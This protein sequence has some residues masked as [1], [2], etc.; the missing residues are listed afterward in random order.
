MAGQV[1][2]RHFNTCKNTLEKKEKANIS[3]QRAAAQKKSSHTTFIGQGAV[4]LNVGNVLVTT[5]DKVL[6]T[7]DYLIR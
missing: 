7:Q 1:L 4:I 6:N 3:L 2:I 5:K